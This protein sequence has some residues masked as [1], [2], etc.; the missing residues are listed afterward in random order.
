MVNKS[1]IGQTEI[2]GNSFELIHPSYHQVQLYQK[3]SLYLDFAF[4]ENSFI[5]EKRNSVLKR[6]SQFL[7]P[8]KKKITYLANYY[9]HCDKPWLFARPKIW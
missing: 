4:W 3:L 8:N 5:L 9:S 6:I 2:E 7:F 1:Y